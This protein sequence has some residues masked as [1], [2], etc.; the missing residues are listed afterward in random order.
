MIITKDITIENIF[1]DIDHY[2][3]LFLEQGILVFKELNPTTLQEWQLMQV[4]G[5][6]IGWFP[7]SSVSLHSGSPYSPTPIVDH[8]VTF[9]RHGRHILADEIFIE[10]HTERS[11]RKNFQI[12]ALW[13]MRKFD[14]DSKSGQ[15]GFVNIISFFD[16]LP[17]EWQDF[18]KKC[19]VSSLVHVD[20]MGVVTEVKF[21]ES[22]PERYIVTPHHVTKKL[23]Y[24]PTLFGK[25]YLRS[26]DGLLPTKDEL[27]LYKH[28]KSWTFNEIVNKPENQTWHS[29][30]LGDT[31]IVDFSIMVHAVKGG[32]NLGERCISRIW[33]YEFCPY[34]VS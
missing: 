34:T 6:K 11:D 4:F 19:K 5:D 3:N 28:I 25:D 27:E 30:D 12:G 18:L 15:T 22:L 2:V 8:K 14:C 1:N 31:V 16:R 23:V 26:V 13:S 24:R 33:A 32:F 17:K 10:W 29:W 20:P 21:S 7:N 9:E